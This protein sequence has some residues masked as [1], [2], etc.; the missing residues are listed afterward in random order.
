[1]QELINNIIRFF[2]DPFNDVLFIFSIVLLGILLQVVAF[3]MFRRVKGKVIESY[4]R[5]KVGKKKKSY[6]AF[7]KYSYLFKG[8]EY[9]G[10]SDWAIKNYWKFKDQAQ[11]LVDKYQAGKQ[12]PILV[13]PILPHQSIP[14][15]TINPFF[16][17][18]EIIV[19]IFLGIL[20][21]ILKDAN[22]TFF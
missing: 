21:L 15:F 4:V 18:M 17:F 16:I 5:D 3:F 6:F 10:S 12:I 7:V 20:L 1:M 2:F 13:N 9:V 11:D 14:V 8:E 19:L 22:I